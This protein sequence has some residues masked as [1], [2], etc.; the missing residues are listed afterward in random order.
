[1]GVSLHYWAVPPSSG[2]FK[3]LQTDR[4]SLA[5]MGA[6]FPHG[7][8]IYFFFDGHSATER[9]DILQEVIDRH[10]RFL[11]P[12]ATAM[13]V[14]EEFR[15]EVGRTRLSHPGVERRGC[16]LEKTGF[17]VQ[18]RLS[19]ALNQVRD[20]ASE[21][22][23]RLL[24][25]DQLHGALKG[26]EVNVEEFSVEEL[27]EM[28]SD[29]ARQCGNFVSPSLVSEGAELLRALDAEALFLNDAVWQLQ[30]FQRWRRLYLEVAAHDEALCCG[31]VS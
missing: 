9:E 26:Q 5:L 7:S 31:V 22:V 17:L 19:E 4:P 11:G 8:G 14:I 27:V 6:L 28:A 13:R 29:L 2:L 23:E 10:Q 3:R 16:S 1:M 15:E 25:G 24:Y 18:E 30:S 12:E 21:F 20:D